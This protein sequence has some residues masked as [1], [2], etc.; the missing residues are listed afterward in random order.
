MNTPLTAT[1]VIERIKTGMAE[2]G[3]EKVLRDATDEQRTA[4]VRAMSQFLTGSL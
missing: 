2:S 4:I 1:E 3:L